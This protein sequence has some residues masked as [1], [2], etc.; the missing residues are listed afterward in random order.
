MDPRSQG[1]RRAGGRSSL[2]YLNVGRRGCSA[3]R[4]LPIVVQL[5][6]RSH[7]WGSCPRRNSSRVVDSPRAGIRVTD[8][9]QQ[10]SNE[11]PT[12]SCNESSNESSNDSRADF[13]HTE[14]RFLSSVVDLSERGGDS[15]E[16]TSLSA[17]IGQGLHG[18]R[19][20]WAG[21][22][23]NREARPRLHACGLINWKIQR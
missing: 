15:V 10:N 13:P 5:G 20:F 14:L 16:Q 9:T 3:V 7:A 22:R 1:E 4:H 2:G 21:P 18:V 19:P 11:R 23:P 12:Q 6:P 17:L 8:K